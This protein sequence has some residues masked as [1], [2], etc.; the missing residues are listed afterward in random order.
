M[1]NKAALEFEC[2][3]KEYPY[4]ATMVEKEDPSDTLAN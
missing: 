2:K 3:Y 4:K 1:S